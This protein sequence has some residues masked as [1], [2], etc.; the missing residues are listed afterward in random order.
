MQ[1]AAPAP[2]LSPLHCGADSRVKHISYIHTLPDSAL[3]ASKTQ[4]GISLN[5]PLSTGSKGRMTLSNL[6]ACC[7]NHLEADVSYLNSTVLYASWQIYTHW[8]TTSYTLLRS[9]TKESSYKIKM[10]IR[11]W[12]AVILSDFHK[13]ITVL[14]TDLQNTNRY[15]FPLKLRLLQGSPIFVTFILSQISYSFLFCIY[16]LTRN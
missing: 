11:L 7:R 8:G 1:A 16:F 5:S 10:Q 14:A 15:L 9:C 2:L 6:L 13:T 3:L 4:C 12:K